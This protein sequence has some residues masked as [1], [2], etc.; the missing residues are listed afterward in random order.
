MVRFRASAETPIFS[1]PNAL[2][3]H[4]SIPHTQGGGTHCL[5]P[6]AH[7]T[8]SDKFE[9]VGI[10]SNKQASDNSHL[11]GTFLILIRRKD[12]HA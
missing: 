11:N 1:N 6:K 8:M 2:Q 7:A 10:T 4:T 5:D 9:E 12:P 3:I